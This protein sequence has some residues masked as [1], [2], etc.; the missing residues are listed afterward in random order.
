MRRIRPNL[1]TGGAP[2]VLQEA[3]AAR[4]ANLL[5]RHGSAHAEDAYIA[6]AQPGDLVVPTEALSEQ[7]RAALAAEQGDEPVVGLGG[8]LELGAQGFA[9]GLGVAE[10]GDMAALLALCRAMH[11]ETAYRDIPFS[12]DAMQTHIAMYLGAP[13][14]HRVFVHKRKGQLQGA[15]FGHV[16]PYF[17]S[18]ARIAND[19]LFYVYPAE[20]SLSLA[21]KLIRA[22]EVWVMTCNVHEICLSVSTGLSGDRAEKLLNRQGFARVGAIFK[23]RPV[24]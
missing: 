6:T 8:E 24:A 12:E 2:A 11:G 18:D 7:T 20:R 22:F 5:G 4:E 21:R 1:I 14:T 3:V 10:P 15:L 23:K 19:D 17:F 9:D 13:A 16:S